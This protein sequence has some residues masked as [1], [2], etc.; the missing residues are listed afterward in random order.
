[1]SVELTSPLGI[2][3]V[4]SDGA[5]PTLLAAGYVKADSAK[6]KPKEARP[7]VTPRRKTARK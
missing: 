5:A 4:A 7:K 2:A 6:D 3:V 1:M